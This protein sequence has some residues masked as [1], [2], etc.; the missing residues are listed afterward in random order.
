MND[1]FADFPVNIGETPEC[2]KC[3]LDIIYEGGNVGE[4]RE[5][6]RGRWWVMGGRGT[7]EV[8]LFVCGGDMLLQVGKCCRFTLISQIIP[9]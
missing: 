6:R 3:L 2:K 1:D 4:V 5:N 9:S 7:S 8:C